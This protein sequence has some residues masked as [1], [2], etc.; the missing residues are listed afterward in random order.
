MNAH[1]SLVR[2]V[3]V[4]TDNMALKTSSPG[5]SLFALT[6]TFEF[7]REEEEEEEEE[8]GDSGVVSILDRFE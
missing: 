3:M 1:C 2:S 5:W 8:D 7:S 6:I 4:P